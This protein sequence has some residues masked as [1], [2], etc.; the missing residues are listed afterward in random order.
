MNI[1]VPFQLKILYEKQ[2]FSPLDYY[3][4][5]TIGQIFAETNPILLTTC[6]LVSKKL[7]QGHICIDI[8]E[9]GNTIQ[10]I[11][12]QDD[13]GVSLPDPKSWETA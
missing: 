10:F 6:A 2:F 13:T 5:K 11:S 8:R 9:L 1:H 3:F 4:A 12:T 7:S